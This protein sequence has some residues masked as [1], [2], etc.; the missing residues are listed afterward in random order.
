[1]AFN[2]ADTRQRA[3][4][5]IDTS[6]PGGN[7]ID[8]KGYNKARVGHGT[9]VLVGNWQ[10]EGVLEKDMVEK[11]FDLSTLRKDGKYY[12]GG[13]ESTAYL[14]ASKDPHERTL[15]SVTTHRADFTMDNAEKGKKRQPNLGPRSQL[16]MQQVIEDASKECEARR[17]SPEGEP[18]TTTYRS[19][20]SDLV[21]GSSPA[22]EPRLELDAT[23]QPLYMSDKPITV[24]TKNPVTQARMVVH[25]V[26]QEPE[27]APQH[28]RNTQFTNSKYAA[29]P[30]NWK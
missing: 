24:Y 7:W 17:R 8:E 26:T 27:L 12:H 5:R 6:N 14:L 13:F 15:S 1:M 10:E 30:C 9:R 28:G 29:G 11:G 4:N 25:G 18:L 3:Y 16:L 21:K 19:T 22:R 20:L 23:G 2:C